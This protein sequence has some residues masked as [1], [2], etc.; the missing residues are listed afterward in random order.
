MFLKLA[1]TKLAIF[2]V[3][4]QLT[5]ECY[6]ITK[7]FP[8]E[9]KYAMVQQIRRAVLS[10]HLNISEG[11]SRK[12]VGER[13]PFYEVARGSLIEVDT[14]F[15]VAVELKYCSPNELNNLGEC[16]INTFKQLTGLMRGNELITDH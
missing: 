1:H 14:A 5:L 3:S 10:V 7:S 11:C 12:S 13:R 6:S 4:K 8:K 9:E 15:D 2:E 16:L